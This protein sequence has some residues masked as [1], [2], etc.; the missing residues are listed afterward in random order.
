ASDARIETRAYSIASRPGSETL[1][2][3]LRR[4]D[5]GALSPRLFALEPGAELFVEPRALGR[6]TLARV[7]REA[8]VVMI[9]TG[10]G[11][12]PFGSMTRTFATGERWRTLTVL[13]GVA[14]EAELAYRPE[15]EARARA[16]PRFRYL[17][18]LS[19]ERP[20][21]WS[22][23]YGRV[24]ELLRPEIWDARAS[25]PLDPASSQ[26]LLC[27]NPAMIVEVTAL[28]EARGFRRDHRSR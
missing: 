20:A 22:G 6:F 23:P 11:L 2:F 7:P 12:A 24:Q 8:D 25:A 10:T 4:V 13:H 16:D 3:F 28:L 27:G 9:A 19:R 14:L 17:P 26:V 1:E 5:D 18:I 21:R 15:L